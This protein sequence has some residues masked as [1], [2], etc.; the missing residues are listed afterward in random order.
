MEVFW[1]V[2]ASGS[3]I[4]KT[5]VSLAVVVLLVTTKNCG[6]FAVSIYNGIEVT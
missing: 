5:K 1:G 6:S 3:I 4:A 2:G